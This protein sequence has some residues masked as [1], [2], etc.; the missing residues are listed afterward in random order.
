[1]KIS[2]K[3]ISPHFYDYHLTAK[4]INTLIKGLDVK[5]FLIHDITHFVVEQRLGYQNGF[6]GMLAQGY[7]ST[8]LSGKEN[9][10]TPLLRAVEKIV[11]PV[12]SVYMG[13]IQQEEFEIYTAHLDVKLDEEWLKTCIEHIT[14]IETAWKRLKTGEQLLLDWHM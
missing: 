10:L 11:G 6:W 12:Q 13:F 4:N 14:Q 5:T 8:Q 2:I 9:Q 1:M 7:S 3:K